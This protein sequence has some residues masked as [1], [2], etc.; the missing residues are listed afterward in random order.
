MISIFKHF[1]SVADYSIQE[2]LIFLNTL[3]YF[4]DM[5]LKMW[6]HFSMCS[7]K[8]SIIIFDSLKLSRRK[9]PLK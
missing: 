6:Q 3:R 4:L 9:V 7:W 8:K 1:A 5:I 2:V